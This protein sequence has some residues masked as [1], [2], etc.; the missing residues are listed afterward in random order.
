[1]AVLLIV[2]FVVVQAGRDVVTGQ[3]IFSDI[4]P[5]KC[6]EVAKVDDGAVLLNACTGETRPLES[7]RG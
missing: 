2:G 6:F 1:M 5:I 7:D 4:E 3:N